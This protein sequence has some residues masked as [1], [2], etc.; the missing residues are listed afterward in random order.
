MSFRE[1]ARPRQGNG[2]ERIEAEADGDGLR[3]D[4]GGLDQSGEK[5]RRVLRLKVEIEVHGMPASR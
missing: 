3:R 4:R 5:A 1:G 2:A